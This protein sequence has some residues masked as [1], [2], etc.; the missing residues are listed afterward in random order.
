MVQGPDRQRVRDDQLREGLVTTQQLAAL[1]CRVD[2]DAV[3]VPAAPPTSGNVTV[4]DAGGGVGLWTAEAAHGR[5]VGDWILFADGGNYARFVG[6]IATVPSATTYTLAG[7]SF[8]GGD[9]GTWKL[10]FTITS[11]ENDGHDFALFTTAIPHG[12]SAG[13]TVVIGG[14]AHYASGDYTVDSEL[15]TATQF[16]S[17]AIAY[18]ANDSG[19]GAE[20]P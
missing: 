1:L 10:G 18:V 13:N 12:L 3:A 9:T 19:G 5:S 11:D 7:W 14:M 4:T 17:L 20:V 16:R 8:D 2:D 15:L 6:Q